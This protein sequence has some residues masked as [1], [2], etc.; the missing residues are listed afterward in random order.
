MVNNV[1]NLWF[2]DDLSKKNPSLSVNTG[3]WDKP[4]PWDHC[5]LQLA[6]LECD[7]RYQILELWF[8][9]HPVEPKYDQYSHSFWIGN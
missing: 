3:V 7:I 9:N 1:N 5:Y 4:H 6:K 2:G 8:T